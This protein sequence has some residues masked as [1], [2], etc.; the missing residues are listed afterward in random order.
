MWV[1]SEDRRTLLNLARCYAILI[2]P[3]DVGFGV[4]AHRDGAHLGVLLKVCDTEAE[5]ERFIDS[6]G[7]SLNGARREHERNDGAVEGG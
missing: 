4:M 2:N 7:A 5:A 3:S 6:L 1:W